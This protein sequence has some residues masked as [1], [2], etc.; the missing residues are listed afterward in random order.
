MQMVSSIYVLYV[1]KLLHFNMKWT[2]YA[3]QT[4]DEWDDDELARGDQGISISQLLEESDYK[5][6]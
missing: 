5:G 4:D 1:R 2:W 6:W 3:L